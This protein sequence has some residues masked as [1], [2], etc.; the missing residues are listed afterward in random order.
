M[1]PP[2][3]KYINKNIETQTSVLNQIL[4]LNFQHTAA[5]AAAPILSEPDKHH[6]LTSQTL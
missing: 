1:P 3:K 6:R 2:L 4:K 5:A